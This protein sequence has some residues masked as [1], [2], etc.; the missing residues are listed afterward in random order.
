MHTKAQRWFGH[1]VVVA[2]AATLAVGCNDDTPSGPTP[3]LAMAAAPA[4][5]TLPVGCERLQ[6]PS[7][8]RLVFSAFARGVQIYR[9]DG[10]WTLVAP[11][12]RLYAG[13][14][15]T[16]LIGTH[17]AGPTWET[18]SG[19]TVTASVRERCTPSADAIQWLLLDV[20]TNRGPGV[21]RKA[22]VIQRV[23]TVGGKAPT[24]PG[25]TTGETRG[26]DYTAEYLF[27]ETP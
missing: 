8:S 16:G 13:E 11:L 2:L 14:R 6:V 24:A 21:L 10:A 7:G 27:Y 17:Y 19:D 20:G 9:W 26:M 23:H 4:P 3:E 22:T 18:T 1:S 5:V 12:A 25:T 15:A